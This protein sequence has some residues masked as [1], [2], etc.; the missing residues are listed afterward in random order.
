ME[1]GGSNLKEFL[2]NLPSF[3]SRVML[4]YPNLD[5]PEF[6]VSDIQDTS[7]HLHYFS[8]RPGLQDF[9][10]GL[11]SGLGKMFD[12]SVN[13]N[14]LQSRTRDLSMKYIGLNGKVASWILF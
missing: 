3:H 5:P 10:I 4:M 1:G 14:L 13:I 2:I 6:K 8:K 11:L 12:V 9:M 7:L